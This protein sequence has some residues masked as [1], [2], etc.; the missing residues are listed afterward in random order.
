MP[1]VVDSSDRRPLAVSDTEGG[2][3]IGVGRT[4]FR[5]LVRLGEIR[6]VKI[7]RRLVVPVS[8]LE[9]YLNRQLAGR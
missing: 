3:M 8:E 9:S 6:A 7:G 5:E 1:I 2:A 4:K